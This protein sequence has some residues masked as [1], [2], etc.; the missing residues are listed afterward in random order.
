MKK[1]TARV[2]A[3][4]L[5]LAGFTAPTSAET[6]YGIAAVG[7]STSLLS[8]DSATPGSIVS[9]SFVSGLQSNETIVGIDFRDGILFVPDLAAL[10]IH[11]GESS[12]EEA[13]YAMEKL[14]P[15]MAAVRAAADELEGLVADDTW[16]LPTYQEMLHIL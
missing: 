11:A 3:L 7:N 5:V 10:G 4:T 16:P 6:I 15:A 1:L 9:G 12:M 2:C 13:V 14:I 8:W